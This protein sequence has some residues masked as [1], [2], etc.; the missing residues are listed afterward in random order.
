MIDCLA[1]TII[2][3]DRAAEPVGVLVSGSYHRNLEY[4][5]ERYG[6]FGMFDFFDASRNLWQNQLSG[7]IPSQVGLLTRLT[8][9]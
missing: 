9:L 3:R 2:I 8:F 4:L 7:T 6:L 5:L 1:L